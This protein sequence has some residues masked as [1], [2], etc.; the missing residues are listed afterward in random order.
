MSKRIEEEEEDDS[1][2]T[3]KDI[4]V[5][6][7]CLAAGYGLAQYQNKRRHS[8]E[9]CYESISNPSSL[10]DLLADKVEEVIQAGGQAGIR[11]VGALL[12]LVVQNASG[13][14][15]IFRQAL[16][17]VQEANAAFKAA[18]APAGAAQSEKT[19]VANAEIYDEATGTWIPI[20]A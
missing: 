7:L 2:N 1:S 18:K 10:P 11:K 20:N 12:E 5:M 14:T 4:G 3:V 15:Q 16:K 13:D 17:N 19:Y 6:F 9:I 8:S